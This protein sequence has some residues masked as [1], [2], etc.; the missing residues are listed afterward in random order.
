MDAALVE[1]ANVIPMGQC[2]MGAEVNACL[3]GMTSS[4]T[5]P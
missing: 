1:D 3:F 2:P 4:I 5:D